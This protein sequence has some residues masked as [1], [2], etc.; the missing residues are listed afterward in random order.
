[1]TDHALRRCQR[2]RRP[3]LGGH[4]RAQPDDRHVLR[5]RTLRRPARGPVAGRAGRRRA[6]SWSGPP[7]RPRPSRST[8]LS[9]EE[10]ITR[11][12]LQVIGELQIE[13]DDQ[14]LHQLRVVDQM[15]G[16]QQLLPQLTAFQ[17]VDTPERLEAFIARLHAYPAFMAA[18]ADIL[19]EALGSGLTAPS[20]VTERTIAQLERMLAI[21]IDQ[22][23]VPGSVQGA[24]DED[25]ER[26]RDDRPRRGLPGRRGLPRGAPRRV[27]P[28]QPRGAGHLVRARTASAS[29]G[30]PSAAGRR[31]SMDPEEIHRDR[32]GRAR[33]DRGG[34]ARDRPGGRLRRRH[35]RPTARRWTTT[36]GN[37][38]GTQG[39]ARRA[40]AARTSSARWPT[41]RATSAAC[42]GP[43]CEVRPVEEYKEKDAPV[44][45]LLPAVRR[46]LTATAST[47]PTATTCRRASTPSSPSTTYHEAAPGHHFQIAL[48]MENPRPHH[49]PPARLADGR[50]RVRRGLGP[51][52]RAAR[53]RDGP[54]P[55]RGRAVRD[56]RRAGLAG[57]AA[58][59]RHR[60]PRAALGAPAV[61]RLPAQRR[62]PVRDRRGHRDRPLHLLAGP[63]ADLHA[64]P[65]PDRGAPARDRRPRRRRASTCASST[66]R[67]SA[68]ARCRWR[69]S[70]A[71]CRPGWPSRPELL[72]AA[73][74]SRSRPRSRPASGG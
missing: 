11:D 72:P 54:V 39:R 45:L 9:T 53:R 2:P 71:S 27:P 31:S 46:R 14:G 6:R 52:Q 20:I 63:G 4:P 42:P 66:T 40:R 58:R 41:R 5:R 18:N 30:R 61:D 17:P 67:S 57:R 22:A 65:A 60:P 3:V 62:R 70:P 23:I 34:A 56:A 47:T 59:R 35:R 16:P 74:R 43:G 12:M 68:T 50:W 19:R 64:R 8:G 69:R 28:R 21:P 73:P 37:T 25:R 1:M 51:V 48:E 38:P 15:G 36:P 33:G 24:S 32:P 44:R 49:V 26:I 7:P 13:E 29:T 55:L 10:R